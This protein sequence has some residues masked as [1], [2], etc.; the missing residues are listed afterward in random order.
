M[1]NG[2]KARRNVVAV[3]KPKSVRADALLLLLGL[4]QNTRNG[5][6]RRRPA[7][8]NSG[9]SVRAPG[10]SAA[11]TRRWRAVSSSSSLTGRNV[12]ALVT[13]GPSSRDT[14]TDSCG[15]GR[16]TLRGTG[17]SRSTHN[18]EARTVALGKY[19]PPP[20]VCRSL[21]RPQKLCRLRWGGRRFRGGGG[22]DVDFGR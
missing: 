6:N 17:V 13:R 20:W 9:I 12:V 16:K 10:A 18:D 5:T 11:A 14:G 7:W 21:C 4:F 15:T 2:Q 19:R 3:V 1:L 22:W 8:K